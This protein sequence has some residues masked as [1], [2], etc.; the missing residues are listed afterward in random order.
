MSSVLLWW[1]VE[2][3]PQ[4]L[5]QAS[6]LSI[7]ELE[8]NNVCSAQKPR[9][10]WQLS[11]TKHSLTF[12]PSVT[13][14]PAA[15]TEPFMI[16]S[17]PTSV[18]ASSVLRI[19]LSDKRLQPCSSAPS[20]TRTSTSSRTPTMRQRS[21]TDPWSLRACLDSSR[22]TMCS[23][24][25]CSTIRAACCD[26]SRSCSTTLPSPAS[27]ST[28]ITCPQPNEGALSVVIMPTPLT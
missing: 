9:P 15:T 7:H 2:K 27:L 22:S 12:A 20:P 26:V 4:K 23:T 13:T 17:G 28:G 1:L 16:T 24:S 18:G 21:P 14:A 25:G 10:T 8:K 19:V 6:P 5:A 3:G 11:P